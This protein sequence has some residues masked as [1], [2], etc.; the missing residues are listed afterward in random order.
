MV[1]LHRLAGLYDI[2]MPTWFLAPIADLSYRHG[3][4]GYLAWRNWFHD[5]DSRA[6]E[7]FK[8]SGSGSELGMRIRIHEPG[9]FSKLTKK[10]VAEI[11]DTVFAKT[12]PKRSF[13]MTEYEHFGLVFTKTR[14][15]KF[16]HRFPAFQ[17]GLH[18][19]R[20]VSLQPLTSTTNTSKQE[21]STGV[22]AFPASFFFLSRSGRIRFP[23]VESTDPIESESKTLSLHVA[24]L[25][26]LP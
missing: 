23:K 24:F 16:G 10:P 19:S 25:S 2:P 1:K 4:P 13:S 12:S 18:L 6:P 7:Q 14:V 3:P 21:M 5:I 26:T 17:T 11:I 20:Y 8:N 9:N 15:Y 22:I